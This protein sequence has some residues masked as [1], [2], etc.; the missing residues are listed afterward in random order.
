MKHF[1][2]LLTLLWLASAGHSMAQT[3]PTDSARQYLTNLFAP[4]DKSQLPTPYLEDYGYRFMPL[5]LF[6]GT[7]S[8][9]AR[10]SLPVWRQLFATVVSGTLKGSDDLPALSDINTRLTQQKNASGA[11]PLLIERLDYATLRPNAIQA[12]LLRAQNGQLFD[13]A[14]RSQSPYVVHTM[15]AAA[16]AYS[17]SPTASVSFI[18]TQQL[19]IQS[20]G[21]SV[22]AL[23]LD[24]GDGQGYRAA[25]WNSALAIQYGSAG[26]YRV[27]I[28]ISYTGT[29]TVGPG[30][31]ESQ[32]DLQVLAAD[33]A[34]QS[35]AQKGPTPQGAYGTNGWVYPAG[36]LDVTF[37]PTSAHSGGKVTIVYG[38][39]SRRQITKPL[40]VVE[41]YDPSTIAPDV[42][43]NY[44]VKTFLRSINTINNNISVRDEFGADNYSSSSSAAYDLIFIDYNN[45]TDDI[46]R[47]AALFED[48][49]RYVN[50]Q[51]LGGTASGQ[52]N[53]VL[54]ISM[55]GLV[56][57]YGL[58]EMEK[59]QPGS[60]NT[61]LL[62]THD[63]PHRGANTPLGI[64]ALT[65]EGAS[66]WLGQTI[67]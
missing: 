41:G 59:A 29:A 44:S 25:T 38:G 10:T 37:N 66:T 21:G 40:I 24:F 13:V 22:Q 36:A 19:H 43:D 42:Q 11:I 27:K 1:Y 28:K 54:G 3:Q 12:G 57:R 60:T 64:Q 15:F 34:N 7:L 35:L 31:Y 26:T 56:A 49:V 5:R 39:L 63:S 62:V 14:G 45:G 53:V 47:N 51:K 17:S 2:F 61:R 55:G 20:G 30:T 6:N 18:F 58:A 8:D 48:V 50:Q 16:P 4:L 65:R 33:P 23:Y 67:N 52:Q 32:F 46:R 9:S